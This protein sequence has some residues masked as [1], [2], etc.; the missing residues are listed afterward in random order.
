M[1]KYS[2]AEVKARRRARLKGGASAD[3]ASALTAALLRWK[4][5]AL[6]WRLEGFITSLLRCW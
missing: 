6:A 2:G 5:S 3:Q 4:S 1:T